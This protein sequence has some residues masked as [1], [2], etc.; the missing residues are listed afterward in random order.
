[1][2]LHS[3]V[4]RE[5]RL[6]RYVNKEKGCSCVRLPFQTEGLSSDHMRVHNHFLLRNSVRFHI[7]WAE[8]QKALGISAHTER[9]T[10][11]L[12]QS[13]PPSLKHNCKKLWQFVLATV[14][15]TIPLYIWCQTRPASRTATTVASKQPVGS[16]TWVGPFCSSVFVNK[17]PPL[18]AVQVD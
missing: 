6:P 5:P 4:F 13:E 17:L 7:S 1:M 14:A 12:I 8:R 2:Y 18:T 15:C 10:W 16:W 3:W 9:D 11:Q